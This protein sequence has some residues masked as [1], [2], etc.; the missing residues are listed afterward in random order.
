M[1]KK[2][3]IR[4]GRKKERVGGE[5]VR[6]KKAFQ[7]LVYIREQNDPCQSIFYFFLQFFHR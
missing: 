4:K 6:E 7:K 1:K 5:G 2:I 3:K